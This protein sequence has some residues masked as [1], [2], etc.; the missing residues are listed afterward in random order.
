M[1]QNATA[2]PS[3]VANPLVR[4]APHD[5]AGGNEVVEKQEHSGHDEQPVFPPHRTERRAEEERDGQHGGD[6]RIAENGAKAKAQQQATDQRPGERTDPRV[7]C[8]FS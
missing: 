8:R 1:A 3:V 7:A 5:R 2:A 6:T 4:N